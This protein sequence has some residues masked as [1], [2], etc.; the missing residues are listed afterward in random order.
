[1]KINQLFKSSISDD[2]LLKILICYGFNSIDDEHSFCKSDL[3]KLNTLNKINALKDEISK[4]YLPCKAK[5]YLDNLD[6]NNCI[7]ILRQ[8][9]RLHNQLLV[10]KQ[11]YIKQKKTTIYSI[12]KFNEEDKNFNNIEINSKE[13]TII[14][15]E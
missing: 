15:F 9:L 4:H 11:K 14:E 12:R 10:S 5:I 8:I 1:M 13:K 6:I 3:E 2:L 7:T